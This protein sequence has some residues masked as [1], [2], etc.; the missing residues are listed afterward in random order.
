[1]EWVADWWSID[2]YEEKVDLDPQGPA[3]GTK[4]VEKGGWWGADPYVGRGAYRHFEDPPSYQDHHIG[5]RIV[6]DP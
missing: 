6:S 4:K 5:V 3:S 1:M 2:Y